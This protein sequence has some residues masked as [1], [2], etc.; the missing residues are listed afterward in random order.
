MSFHEVLF[1]EAIAY[2]ASGGP[3]FKTAVFTAD[4]G[5]EQRTLDWK[6]VR[7]EYDVDHTVKRA[8]QRDELVNFFMCRRGMAYGF[9]F[10]DWNDFTLKQELIGLGDGVRSAFQITKRYTSDQGLGESW[11]YDRKITKI[12]WGTVAG[13]TVGGAVASLST[14]PNWSDVTGRPIAYRLDEN[15]GVMTFREP[16]SGERYVGTAD[17]TP[18]TTI[19]P[20][21][22]VSANGAQF[23]SVCVD[24]VAGF[25][26]YR[27]ASPAGLRRFGLAD[28]VETLQR[29]N[30]EIAFPQTDPTYDNQQIDALIAAGGGYV[31]VLVGGAATKVLYKLDADYAIV[32]SA[33]TGAVSAPPAG[34]VGVSAFPGVV[35]NDGTRLMVV[36]A[37]ASD[38]AYNIFA[39]ADLTHL[40]SVP[41]GALTTAQI[42]PAGPYYDSGFVVASASPAGIALIDDAGNALATLGTSTARA[43]WCMWDDGPDKGV[44]VGW[45]TA[46]ASDSPAYVSKLSVETMSIVWTLS[47]PN[48]SR[49]NPQTPVSGDLWLLY[50][51]VLTR[52]DTTAGTKRIRAC[53]EITRAAHAYDPAG[54]RIV[55]FPA[56]T[57]G[58]A[59]RIA[60]D[61]AG[62]EV[63]SATEIRIGYGEFHVPVRFNTDH[64]D[65]SHDTYSTSSWSGIEL[66]EVRDW[67]E[68]DL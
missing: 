44:L 59:Y 9:R 54:Q 46:T 42:G 62:V 23:E 55:T 68:I 36:N 16:P 51:E 4:S 5:Y 14:A 29:T 2:G 47:V 20:M 15:T 26:H 52:I 28:G 38:H 67:E 25:L 7:A 45:R 22:G 27:G 13:V 39:T 11:T 57:N 63:E 18:L 33:G 19:G 50:D 35:S 3:K 66:I 6:D 65:I 61:V 53:D 32:A 41:S 48:A 31:Y 8:E 49:P 1:P 37:A 10:K 60:T 64:L 34:A 58:L 24:H 12:A 30:A 56:T 21:S 43:Q 40:G 17:R